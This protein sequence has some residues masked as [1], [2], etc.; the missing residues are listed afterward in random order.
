MICRVVLFKWFVEVDGSKPNATATFLHGGWFSEVVVVELPIF[1]FS[2]MTD[3]P[4]A[5][6]RKAFRRFFFSRFFRRARTSITL[7]HGIPLG[8][9]RHW[10]VVVAVLT[11]SLSP[12]PLADGSISAGCDG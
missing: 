9:P 10:M 8:P 12:F 7:F 3:L 2:V 1:K 5:A 6:D 4:V 11:R